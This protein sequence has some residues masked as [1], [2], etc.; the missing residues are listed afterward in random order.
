MEEANYE[1]KISFSNILNSPQFS[2]QVCELESLLLFESFAIQIAFCGFFT[3]KCLGIKNEADSQLQENCHR[4]SDRHS[5]CPH[6]RIF[7]VSA[8]SKVHLETS[9]N[10]MSIK[11]HPTLINNFNHNRIF[12]FDQAPKFVHCSTKFLFHWFS[13]RIFSISQI[14]TMWW[15]ERSHEWTK[16]DLSY[17]S[18][19]RQIMK[20]LN[21]W[22]PNIREWK[23]R[24]D[25]KDD[26][27]KDTVTYTMRN[28][29]VFRP[30]LSNGLTGDEIVTLPHLIIIGTVMA[31]RRDREPMVKL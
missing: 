5:L 1:N 2:F 21:G 24:Y 20:K 29:F 13:R 28:R 31:V 12:S 9:K 11:F 6:Q 27:A 7:V 16:S 17:L 22:F 15:T 23:E 30:D 4:F 18:E 14:P 26:P 25:I 3:F 10:F 8:N 19:L